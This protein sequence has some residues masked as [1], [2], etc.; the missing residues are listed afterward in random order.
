MF[1]DSFTLIHSNS[2]QTFFTLVPSFIT[3][4][5]TKS[6]C[7]SGQSLSLSL[8]TNQLFL[9]VSTRQSN[10]THDFFSTSG[11]VSVTGRKELALGFTW[12]DGFFFFYFWSIWWL[13]SNVMYPTYKWNYDQCTQRFINKHLIYS[14]CDVFSASTPQSVIWIRKHTPI[15]R[16]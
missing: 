16:L 6:F 2:L 13:W 4:I 7:P 1:A 12:S 14:G 3:H 15:E 9:L 10:L 8:K 5:Y 11:K